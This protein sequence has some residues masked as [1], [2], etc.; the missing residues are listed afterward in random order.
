MA[1]PIA[2]GWITTAEAAS[3]TGYSRLYVRRLAREGCITAS[4]IAQEWLIERDS[5]L[6]YAR[7]MRALGSQRFNP[8]RQ[9]ESKSGD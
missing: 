9:K 3:L 8:R 5:L 6:D 4:K 2:D 7:Q 1:D